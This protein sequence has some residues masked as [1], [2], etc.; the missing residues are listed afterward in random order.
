MKF[1]N[2]ICLVQWTIKAGM[3]HNIHY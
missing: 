3:T 2:A 1:Y